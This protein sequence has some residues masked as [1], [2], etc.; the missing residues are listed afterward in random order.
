MRFG[1][2]TNLTRDENGKATIKLADFFNSKNIPF[3]MSDELRSLKYDCE[4]L[5]NEKLANASDVI[6][7]FGGDGTILRIVKECAE[8]DCEIFAINLGNIGFLTEVEITGVDKA[9]EE[10]CKKQTTIEKRNLLEVVYKN[11]SFAA[12]NEVVIA[13]GSRTKMVYIDMMVNNVLVDRLRSDGIIVSSPTGS[14]AYSLSAGGPIVTPDVDAFVLTP[15]CPHSFH[16]RPFVISN[17]STI[18]LYL[19][20][21]DP[22]AYLN[23]DGEDVAEME[24]GDMVEI[25]KSNLTAKFVR[26]NC[27]NFYDNI[28]QKLNYW[29]HT[30]RE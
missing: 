12:L 19:L 22:S 29:R 26:L 8:A 3:A 6:V 25:K 24:M 28:V 20:R 23:V 27:Y 5:S 30:D 18:K 16:S 4:Y 15:I 9:I 7:I 13:R 11:K 14:T 2:Y 1:I 21:A 17:D 10:I